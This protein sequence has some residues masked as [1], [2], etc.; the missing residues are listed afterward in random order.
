VETIELLK[1]MIDG[2]LVLFIGALWL[3]TQ[4][5]QNRSEGTKP[6]RTSPSWI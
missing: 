1:L 3:T 5:G 6:R 2:S 4:R